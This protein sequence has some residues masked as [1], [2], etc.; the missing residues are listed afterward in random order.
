MIREKKM[1]T[2]GEPGRWPK[3]EIGKLGMLVRKSEAQLYGLSKSLL[4][5]TVCKLIP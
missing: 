3:A 5:S 2:Q 1:E 4:T